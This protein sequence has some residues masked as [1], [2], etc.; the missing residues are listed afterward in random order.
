MV[1]Y[2]FS[3]LSD[4]ILSVSKSTKNVQCAPVKTFQRINFGQ[5]KT[6]QEDNSKF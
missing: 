1:E 3:T 2:S 5:L 4:N 6:V